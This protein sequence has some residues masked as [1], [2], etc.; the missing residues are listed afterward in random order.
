MNNILCII[1]ARCGSKGIKK[2]NII[3]ICGLP[4]IAYSIKDACKLKQE[5]LISN[6]IVSTD[7]EEIADIAK[8]MAP[9]FHS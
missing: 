9:P 5:G 1:P 2:K 7:C 4:L 6:V 3:D 8:N